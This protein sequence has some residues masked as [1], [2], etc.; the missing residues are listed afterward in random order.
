MSTSG[1]L[2]VCQDISGT[3]CAIFTNFSVPVA[4]G[5][6]SV[7][8]RQGDEIPNGGGSFGGFL[9]QWQC[10]ITRSLQMGSATK[11]VMGVPSAGEV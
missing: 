10:I 7:P 8:F 5:R 11:G 2:S 1:C 3:T 6:G 4:Y 9:L